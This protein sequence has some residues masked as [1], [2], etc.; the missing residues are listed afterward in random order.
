[1]FVAAIITE[2]ITP[3]AFFM[4]EPYKIGKV[5]EKTKLETHTPLNTMLMTMLMM[6]KIVP[7]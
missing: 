5:L 7:C 6:V 3:D 1:V 4:I 2:F